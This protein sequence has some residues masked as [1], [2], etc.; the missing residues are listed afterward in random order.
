ML[1]MLNTVS[2][3]N[4]R[5]NIFRYIDLATANQKQVGITNDKIVIGWFVPN[6]VKV[7]TKKNKVDLFLEDINKLQK[8]YPIREGRNLS[9]DIDKI[10]YGKK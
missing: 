6:T 2:I 9:Q 7:K 10:L 3:T 5:N 4:F 1:F 8:K